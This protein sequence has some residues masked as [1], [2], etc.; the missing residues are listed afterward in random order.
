MH[1]YRRSRYRL[2]TCA[3]LVCFAVCAGCAYTLI[4]G[5]EIN[6]KKAARIE[7]GIQQ[8]RQLG[9]RK[10]VP[11]VVKTPDDVERM[12]IEDLKRDY[13]DEELDADGKA[14][15]MLG[16]Y[17]PGIDLKAETVKL[18]K[19]QIAGFYDP[20]GKQMVLV[21]GAYKLGM[22][23]RTL[24]FA[25]Q[26]DLVGEMLLAHELTHALQDQ[27]F[28]LQD[29]L[30]KLKENG[31][32]EL[33]LKSVAEGDAMLAGFAYIMGKMDDSV[34]DQLA[35]HMEGLPQQFAAE[36]KDT[37][38]AL[39]IPLIF[40]YSDGVRFV[41]RAYNR[42]G[43]A[44]VDALYRRPPRSS[45]QIAD[46]SLYFDDPT[47]PRAVSVGGYETALRGWDKI[48]EDTYGELSLRIILQLA[49]GNGA[50]Q[51]MLAQKWA[52]DRMVILGK[53][54]QVTVVWIIAF[55]DI[56]AAAKFAGSYRGVLDKIHGSSP[57]QVQ[58]KSDAVLVVAGAGAL[59]FDT[60]A[61]AVWKASRIGAAASS[62]TPVLHRA[63]RGAEIA[64]PGA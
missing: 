48:D 43:W 9:F 32:E 56:D 17:P 19:S 50:P 31:D 51:M 38:A 4:H 34:A 39:S 58:L 36:S 53:G 33:A 45:Q 1:R 46:P 41:A 13:S 44:A 16:F 25:M 3:V 60:L 64:A 10:S 24:E 2:V 29:K 14:G 11:L 61:P 35:A 7:A 20:H 28:G 27:S 47:P 55:R 5:G 26:R 40:Q 63:M 49:L 37:P 6:Q 12:V 22:W 15:A 59:Q 8:I 54:R 52:G 42:G 62:P 23:D 21:E 18:L 57:H 30:D